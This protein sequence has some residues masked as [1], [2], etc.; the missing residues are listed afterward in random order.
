MVFFK[1]SARRNLWHR[2]CLL[3]LIQ[4]K[5]DPRN[6]AHSL[7][8]KIHHVGPN[9]HFC[10]LTFR[11]SLYWQEGWVVHIPCIM[12]ILQTSLKQLLS[13]SVQTEIPEM[14]GIS[15]QISRKKYKKKK[16]EKREKRSTLC[17]LAFAR[18][19][20]H[21]FQKY[22]SGTEMSVCESASPACRSAERLAWRSEGGKTQTVANS[23]VADWQKVSECV[24]LTSSSVVVWGHH[25][26]INHCRQQ[27]AGITYS[28]TYSVSVQVC[29]SLWTYQP[30]AQKSYKP[31]LH[32]A[33]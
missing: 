6:T 8:S 1:K 4:K 32:T 31:A 25:S 17:S 29:E 14:L 20:S 23:V 7:A 9:V 24:R 18:A 33:A 30:S 28:C 22:G 16:T 10:P 5:K 19:S 15:Q 13:R 27:A 21:P 3:T 2:S 12:V 11:V 26:A